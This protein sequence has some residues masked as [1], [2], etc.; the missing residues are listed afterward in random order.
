ME[1]IGEPTEPIGEVVEPIARTRRA[2]VVAIAVLV[3]VALASVSV[4]ATRGHDPARPELAPEG[5]QTPVGIGPTQFDHWHAALGVNDCGRWVPNW[6]WPPG[7]SD[8]GGP[9]RAGSGLYAGLHSHGDGLIHIEPFTSNEMGSHA[10]LGLYFRYGGWSLDAT[11]VT[12]V[13]VHE[14]NGS[15]C[16]GE[17]GVLRWAVNGREL[18]G[19]PSEY[20]IRDGD[21]IALVFTTADAPLPLPSAIPSYRALRRI[22]DPGLTA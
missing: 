8:T 17:R 7:A 20:K 19:D 6:L 22:I 4:V 18:H 11:A 16:N 2:S 9:G 12:F 21:V 10:T 14:R 3:V 13:G 5:G 15:L 1:P